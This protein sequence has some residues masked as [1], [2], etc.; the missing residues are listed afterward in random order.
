[1]V[2][3]KVIAKVICDAGPII[4]LDELD[5]V[6]LLSDFR[7]VLVGPLVRAEIAEFR[8]FALAKIDQFSSSPVVATS[9]DPVLLSLCKVFALDAGEMEALLLMKQFPASTLLSDDAAARVVAERMGFSV[10][11]SIGILIR[12]IR[13][14][15]MTP[16]N[17]LELLAQIPERSTLFIKKSILDHIKERIRK[18]Y[19]L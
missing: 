13:R 8:P 15:Q 5:S 1:V 3:N 4:H 7:E 2:Q 10:H 17:V 14:G 18:E 11:G 12:A 16:Q 19:G 6:H 9:K